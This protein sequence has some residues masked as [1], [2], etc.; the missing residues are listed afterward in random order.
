M[1]RFVVAL[2]F[3]LLVQIASVYG[4]KYAGESLTLGAG[5]RPM[6]LGGAYA[7]ISDD[8]S[9]LYY[10]PAGLA[11]IN[12]RQVLLLHSETF[13][14]LVNHDFVSYTNP[15]VLRNR[16]GSVAVGV[17]RV[18]GGG[19]I[20]TEKDPIT[21]GPKILSEASHYDYLLM[22]GGGVSISDKWRVG[23][24]AKIIVRSLAENSA[25]GL[26]LDLGIQYGNAKG[27]AAGATVTNATSTFL[28][29]D[30]G[31]RESILPAL[32]FGAT[33]SVVVNQFT[34]RAVADIDLLFEGRDAAAQIA[35]GTM[36]LDSHLGGEISYHEIVYFRGGSDIGRLTLGVGIRFNRFRL[37]G[38]FLDHNDLDNS[39]RVSL[40]IAL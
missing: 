8:P 3:C 40:N 12:G 37:D 25:W 20:L 9:G 32:K 21:G 34:L 30:N 4:A 11:R 18:G 31:S 36:S 7:A 19:I 6:A 24:S 22:L 10:N 28:S 13:G 16:P 1:N 23:S 5:A 39:Y 26:G 27:F 33:H 29:Y 14:S 35:L 38:A 2:F 17:Y 15:V